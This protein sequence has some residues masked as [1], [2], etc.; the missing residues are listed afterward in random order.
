MDVVMPEDSCCMRE[1]DLDSLQ[2]GRQGGRRRRM[3]SCSLSALSTRIN[4]RRL[5]QTIKYHLISVHTFM[6][7]QHKL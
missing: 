6:T 7:P 5:Q 2:R 3:S 1:T 4:H